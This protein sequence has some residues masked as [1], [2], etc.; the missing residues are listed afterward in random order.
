M[1]QTGPSSPSCQACILNP[2]GF[3]CL[4]WITGL[5]SSPRGP[6]LETP[7]LK[8]SR[9]LTPEPALA[10]RRS[11]VGQHILSLETLEGRAKILD[12]DHI[13]RGQVHPFQAEAGPGH[14]GITLHNSNLRWTS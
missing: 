4:C 3:N 14:W 9:T 13:A 6:G 8:R 12:L 1:T 5:L 11:G 7:L 10:A 2:A